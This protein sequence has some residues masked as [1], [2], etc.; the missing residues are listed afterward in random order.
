MDP[1]MSPKWDVSLLR[2]VSS[3]FILIWRSQT[4]CVGTPRSKVR[5]D[6]SGAQIVKSSLVLDIEA[7]LY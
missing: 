7:Y 3:L 2:I 1:T 6:F 5:L 4:C